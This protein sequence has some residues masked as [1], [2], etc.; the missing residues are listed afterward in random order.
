[1]FSM[2]GAVSLE[3]LD[4]DKDCFFR[5]AEAPTHEAQ[6]TMVS[7]RGRVGISMTIAR[8]FYNA[9]VFVFATDSNCLVA[10][11]IDS[12]QGEVSN[13][14]MRYGLSN[15]KCKDGMVT[16]HDRSVCIRS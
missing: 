7:W 1:M 12:F 16:D 14:V 5:F 4:S 9:P 3:C 10:H 11:I 6:F 8:K 15:F 2:L 13:S